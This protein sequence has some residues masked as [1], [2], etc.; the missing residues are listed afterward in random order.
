MINISLQNELF[1]SVG[2]KTLG[3]S[4]RQRYM[5]GRGDSQ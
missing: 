5:G 3:V 1:Y 2:K 4:Q